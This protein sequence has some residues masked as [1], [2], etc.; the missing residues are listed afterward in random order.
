MTRQLRYG[1]Y[2]ARPMPERGESLPGYCWRFFSSNGHYVPRHLKCS[3]GAYR[4]SPYRK[5]YYEGL[6]TFFGI[7][8]LRELLDAEAEVGPASRRWDG[9]N[10]VR[11]RFMVRHCPECVRIGGKQWLHHELPLTQV[12]TVHDCWLISE[13]SLCEAPLRWNTM[14]L[15][16]QCR[17][18]LSIAEMA[19]RP[20]PAWL[21]RLATWIKCSHGQW[22]RGD[23]KPSSKTSQSLSP[24]ITFVDTVHA[25]AQIEFQRL[26]AAP[27]EEVNCYLGNEDLLRRGEILPHKELSFFRRLVDG[28]Q[29]EDI[30]FV[31]GPL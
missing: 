27:A 10:W 14:Y 11:R 31:R 9:I 15:P 3:F 18:G 8:L 7:E 4:V 25:L 20:A 6:V 1:D 16:W 22:V 23:D 2:P 21:V 30:A 24:D 28:D 5:S 19:V 26:Q 13:C 29:P 12:C 17:C